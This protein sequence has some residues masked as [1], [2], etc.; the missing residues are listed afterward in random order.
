MAPRTVIDLASRLSSTRRGAIWKALRYSPRSN[1]ATAGLG[2]LSRT[3]SGPALAGPG[4]G[5]TGFAIA[6]SGA[7]GFAAA[8]GICSFGFSADRRFAAGFDFAAGLSTSR[9][10]GGVSGCAAAAQSHA[11][12][13]KPG[14]Q[15]GG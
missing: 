8:L 13:D 7:A 11:A 3:G 10:A 6:G 12:E 9:G 5:K 2:S 1:A 15:P 14:R 4:S